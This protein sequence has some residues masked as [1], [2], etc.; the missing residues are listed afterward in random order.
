MAFG[1]IRLQL[2]APYSVT[3]SS[4]IEFLVDEFSEF[5][6]EIGST[7]KY[8]HIFLLLMEHVT[9]FTLLLLMDKLK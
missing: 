9:P 8:V 2:G 3:F 7:N 6:S 4:Q 1:D 5:L